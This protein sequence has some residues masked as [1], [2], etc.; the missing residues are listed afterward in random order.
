MTLLMESL[1]GECD[2]FHQESPLKPSFPG[3]LVIS[4]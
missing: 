3:R 2:A 4:A 1:H